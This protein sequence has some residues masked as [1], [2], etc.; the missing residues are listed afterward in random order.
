MSRSVENEIERAPPRASFTFAFGAHLFTA[1]G[2]GIALLAMMGAVEGR[3]T[4]M[5]AWLGVALVVDGVDGTIARWLDVKRRAPRW[6]GDVLDLVVDILT[7][8]FVPAYAIVAAG[9]LPAGFAL[10]LGLLVVV[11]GVLYFADRRMKSEDNYFF[12]F[13][14]VWNVVAF[15]VFLLPTPPWLNAA[16]VLALAAATFLPIP[17]LHPFRVVRLRALN[18]AL[19]LALAG[20]AAVAIA[21]DM[22]PGA[23]VTAGLCIVGLYFVG[24]G[25][26]RRTGV[27]GR[28]GA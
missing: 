3:W 6:S 23:P 7:Y 4:A 11:T 12:G 13:P 20:L 21:S 15:Y 24:A 25:L 8:V 19:T 9:R 1:A 26:L 14:A 10:P 5:F 16:V 17:F 2:G 22:K 18:I 28:Q 27:S